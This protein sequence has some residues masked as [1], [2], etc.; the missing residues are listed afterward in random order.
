MEAEI[1]RIFANALAWDAILLLDEA[2]TIMLE[3]TPDNILVNAWV[4]ST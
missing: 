2:E 3:R 4:S 1:D